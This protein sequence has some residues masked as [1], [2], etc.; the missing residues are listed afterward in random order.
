MRIILRRNM[1]LILASSFL[2]A[3]FGCGGKNDKTTNDANS[4]V[5]NGANISSICDAIGFDE[6][7]HELRIGDFKNHSDNYLNYSGYYNGRDIVKF[8]KYQ[9]DSI[10]SNSFASIF[11]DTGCIENSF[12]GIIIYFGLSTNPSGEA[13]VEYYLGKVKLIDTDS[14]IDTKELNISNTPESISQFQGELYKIDNTGNLILLTEPAERDAANQSNAIYKENIRFKTYLTNKWRNFKND[15]DTEYIIYPLQI[16]QSFLSA[17]QAST[18][19]ICS[20]LYSPGW[21]LYYQHSVDFSP[22]LAD[23]A[24]KIILDDDKKLIL[25]FQGKAANFSQLCPTK[26]GNLNYKII[27]SDS[28]KQLQLQK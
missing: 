3:S 21:K 7:P 28:Q 12:P 19:Y 22:I 25:S 17:N 2:G 20:G 5:E 24:T 1:L 14:N 9:Y 11:N 26:C 13:K 27:I 18:F 16:V 6:T 23:A 8:S 15:Q 4:V 10:N